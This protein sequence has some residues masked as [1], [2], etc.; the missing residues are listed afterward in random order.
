MKRILSKLLVIS[1]F[2]C[3][4]FSCSDESSLTTVAPSE[5]TSMTIKLHDV[6]RQGLTRTTLNES[7][8][9]VW[10]TTDTIGIFPNEGFQVAFPMA[11]S[12]GTQTAIFKGGGW[13]LKTKYSYSA[14]FPLIGQT[15]LDRTSIP[16]K[17]TGQMQTANGESSHIG[18][19]D[20]M[21]APYCNVNPN[22]GVIF[23]FEH[24]VC[25]L[26]L[27]V[28]MNSADTFTSIVFK[29]NGEFVTEASLNLT[30][31]IVSTVQT[32]QEMTLG[33]NDIVIEEQ[34]Q[35]L[36]AYIV[37]L[38]VDLTGKN[39]SAEICGKSGTV[40]QV[41]LPGMNYE[42]GHLYTASRTASTL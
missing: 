16:L 10:N 19:Y 38:P 1:T 23:D 14:Y 12:T 17:V 40:H 33:L 34:A 7:L 35:V 8:Q 22:G 29:T 11:G 36:N 37:M 21:A 30:D 5:V 9:L 31:G 6:S 3:V 20:Y 2:I 13:G 42:A 32:S 15:Y 27:K 18:K 25:F 41:S 26:Q 28:T 24:L 39:V 4:L